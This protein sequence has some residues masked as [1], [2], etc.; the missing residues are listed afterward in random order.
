VEKGLGRDKRRIY[1]LTG[2]TIQGNQRQTESGNMAFRNI[3]LNIKKGSIKNEIFYRTGK[4]VLLFSNLAVARIFSKT[5]RFENRTKTRRHKGQCCSV[6]LCEYSSDFF[7]VQ[8]IRFMSLT[9]RHRDTR[10]KYTEN[11]LR[12]FN[13]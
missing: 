7:I 4:F 12:I 9:R 5:P 3:I 11:S 2:R 1:Y 10:G 13:L 8:E 6:T